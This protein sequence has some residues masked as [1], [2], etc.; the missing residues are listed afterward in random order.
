[1]RA[2]P[3]RCQPALRMGVR[4]RR[5]CAPASSSASR[6]RSTWKSSS[7]REFSEAVYTIF[8]A[9]RPRRVDQLGVELHP[10]ALVRQVLAEDPPAQ[11]V[12]EALPDAAVVLRAPDR[13]AGPRRHRGVHGAAGGRR[14][15]PLRPPHEPSARIGLVE[16]EAVDPRADVALPR[17]DEPLEDSGDDGKRVH[18]QPP[19]DEPARVR[20][21][22]RELR[23]RQSAS[24]SRAVP[25]AFAASTTTSA[26]ATRTRRLVD[27]L[28]APGQAVAADEDTS[29]ARTCDQHGR[30]A[31]S[32][33][34]SG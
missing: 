29:H 34:A 6:A 33:P 11:T 31:R 19:P 28:G 2:V 10:V 8:G 12:A 25:T 4:N 17:L 22:V 1:M 23:D 18:H 14:Q 3:S 27:V 30:R 21:P 16:L 13:L 9:G 20:K 26:S 24:R 32:P 5:S 15:A 7:R